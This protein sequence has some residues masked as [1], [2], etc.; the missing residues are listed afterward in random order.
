MRQSS[1]AL[2]LAALGWLASIGGALAQPLPPAATGA[3]IDPARL[4]A[5]VDGVVRE[6]MR[7]DHIAGVGVAVVG[8]AGP[9][10]LKGYG[11]AAPGRPA[12][13]DTLF[14]EQSISKTLVWI[15]LMQL[16]DDGK[17]HL[18]DPINADLPPALRIPDEG[19]ATPITIRNL[20]SHAA[21]FEDSAFGHLFVNRPDRLLP[22]EAYLAHY[23]VHRVRPAGQTVVYSNFGGAL[24]GE[25]VT[26]VSG[27]GWE[28]YAEQRILRPLGMRQ[29]TFRQLYPADVAK[30][31]GLPAPMPPDIAAR[32]TD[33]FR[34]GDGGPQVATSELTSDVPAGAM[35]AS[36]RDMAA[37][38]QALLDPS[39]MQSLGV[40]SEQTALAMRSPLVRGPAGFGDMRHGFES[41]A[42]P[43]GVD[44]FGHGGDSIYSAA[45]MTLIPSR[46]LGIF[47]AANTANA[48]GIV[49]RVRQAIVGEFVS[50]ALP[51]PVYARDAAAEAKAYAGDYRSLRRAYLRTERGLSN[52]LL[53]T[54]SVSARPNGDLR[55]GSLLGRSRD[56]V[57][58]GAG[59]YRD[60]DGPRRVAFRPLNG[61]VGLYDPYA[62]VAY[63][64]IGFFQSPGWAMSIILLTA[65]AAAAV[66]TRLARRMLPPKP[67]RTF[68][69]YAVW[70]LSSA[71][72]AWLIGFVLFGA[73]LAKA[74]A[75]PVPGEIMF[76]FPPAPLVAACWAF[77][78]AA[79]LS[80][81]AL[82][83][84]AALARRNG[85]SLLQRS[86]HGVAAASFAACA[87]TFWGL[88]FLGFSGW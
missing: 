72:A 5:F 56:L 55:L 44:A 13:A 3:Q 37:Y 16:V 38:M 80:L 19:F 61:R 43:G 21:G 73:S 35:V 75:S 60:R 25:I 79:V 29:A 51:P 10:L 69:H 32:L 34:P 59:V 86:I 23:R 71:A 9:I 18:D 66:L 74:L 14:H 24:G 12:D 36:P 54:V 83:G 20:M 52:L 39:R 26:R 53:D 85:W 8:P 49:Q 42:L 45:T 1:R 70:T 64:P 40:L 62:D 48:D 15:A 77:A 67:D 84:L 82:P 28:D 58:L 88:G 46:G 47:V 22:L 41:I 6:G 4:E 78:A 30:R 27:L 68:E 76:W 81:V 63:E 65:L 57:P 17:I 2:G 87:I 33:D 31:R 7:E 11:V 50:S